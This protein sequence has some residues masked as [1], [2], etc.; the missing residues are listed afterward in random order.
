MISWE[1]SRGKKSP[2]RAV[3][4]SRIRHLQISIAE[5]KKKSK[6]NERSKN[7]YKGNQNAFRIGTGFLGKEI[8]KLQSFV[9]LL[10]RECLLFLIGSNYIS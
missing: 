2:L 8:I 5:A 9:P 10:L 3:L 1:I 4:F 6:K 7:V